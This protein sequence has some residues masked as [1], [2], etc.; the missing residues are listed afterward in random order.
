M[1]HDD[2]SVVSPTLSPTSGQ[3]WY[4][5]VE[6]RGPAQD[7]AGCQATSNHI[8]SVHD[9]LSVAVV[10]VAAILTN[11][12]HVHFYLHCIFNSSLLLPNVN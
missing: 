8:S 5:H 3:I 12:N 7:D 10:H 4:A 11:E 1:F 9:H 2:N 6:F